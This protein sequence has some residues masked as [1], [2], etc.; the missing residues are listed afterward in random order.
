ME[1]VR[2]SD[3]A[4]FGRYDAKHMVGETSSESIYTH[5]PDLK[6][7]IFGIFRVTG[8]KKVESGLVAEIEL[9]RMVQVRRFGSHWLCHNERNHP[10]GGIKIW[11][12][13]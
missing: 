1:L 8:S 3:S 12:L 10:A 7:Q 11:I 6:H 2:R 13:L 4:W 9:Y 5:T